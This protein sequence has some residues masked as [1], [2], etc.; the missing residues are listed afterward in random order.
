MGIASFAWPSHSPNIRDG[1][2]PTEPTKYNCW[3]NPENIIAILF[4]SLFRLHRHLANPSCNNESSSGLRGVLGGHEGGHGPVGEDLQRVGVEHDQPELAVLRGPLGGPPLHLRHVHLPAAAPEAAVAARG[5]RAE[6]LALL[7]EPLRPIELLLQRRLQ[8]P[9]LLVRVHRGVLHP[10]LL[11]RQLHAEQAPS[12]Q[13]K[14]RASPK[15]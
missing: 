12:R 5:G 8:R 10:P 1:Q 4:T 7:A 9:H 2:R 13:H 14:V 11:A 6:Q 15:V 3:C